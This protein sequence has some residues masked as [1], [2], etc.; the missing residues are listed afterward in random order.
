MY[1][2][3]NK[4]TRVIN[5]F[6]RTKIIRPKDIFSRYGA[7]NN[8]KGG[9]SSEADK[10]GTPVVQGTSVIQS[11]II[12]QETLRKVT[13]SKSKPDDDDLPPA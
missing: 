5:Q 8:P 12:G 6:T 2:S 9:Y 1:Y 13:K 3:P 7:R 4:K 10:E 11:M